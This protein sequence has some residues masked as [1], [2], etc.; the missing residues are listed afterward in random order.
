MNYNLIILFII[1]I[2]LFYIIN[3]RIILQKENYLTYYLPFYNVDSSLLHT[4]YKEHNYSKNYFKKKFNYEVVKLGSNTF[5][6]DFNIL[7]SKIAVDETMT[8]TISSI[9]YD[10]E[11]R[12][13]SDLYYNKI[14]LCIS[15]IIL[16]NYFNI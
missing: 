12:L 4:F 7:L 11:L 13:I 5:A 3:K 2:L 8:Y 10:N 14:N 9:R 6:Y 16:I 15:N 1:I